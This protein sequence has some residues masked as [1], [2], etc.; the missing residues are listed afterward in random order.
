M[1]NGS[2]VSLNGTVGPYATVG[3]N[4]HGGQAQVVLSNSNGG[5]SDYANQT[6]YNTYY[7]PSGNHLYA[8]TMKAPGYGCTEITT[9]YGYGAP[10]V[11]VWDF[12]I[13]NN[14]VFHNARSMNAQFMQTYVR[15]IDGLPRYTVENAFSIDGWAAIIYNYSGGYWEYLYQAAAGAVC[16]GASPIP[17]GDGW[18]IFETHY[19][20]GATCQKVPTMS[21][22]EFQLNGALVTPSV[23]YTY[24]YGDCFTGTN[25][26]VF[27]VVNPN[28]YWNVTGGT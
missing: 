22:S 26:Y 12:C 17:C 18:D 15:T 13:P 19:P 16:S 24:V 4:D 3:Q 11:G 5:S 28:Y 23:S 6:A 25:P 21:S 1:P 7:P 20:A 10:Q 8:P 14:A 2:F 9:I 27:A